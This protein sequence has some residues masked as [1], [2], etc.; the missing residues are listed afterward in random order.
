MKYIFQ[1]KKGSAGFT[2]IE[3]LV[4]MVVLG[5]MIISV[6]ELFIS[7]DATQRR[8]RRLESA[9]RAAESKI[10]SLRNSHYNTLTPGT[11]LDFT[12]ELPPGLPEPRS[13]TVD[14][15]EPAVGLRRLDVT[16]TYREG[17][18]DKE[19]QLSALLGDIGLAQ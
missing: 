10:E 16:V 6:T 18:L 5:I 12:A 9:T 4:A 19:V 14:V 1:N 7:I 13:A 8:S 3:V 15:S 2:I 17:A 11:P